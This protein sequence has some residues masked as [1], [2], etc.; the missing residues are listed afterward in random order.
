MMVLIP[1]SILTVVII[2]PLLAPLMMGERKEQVQGWGLLVAMTLFVMGVYLWRGEPDIPSQPALFDT[3]GPLAEKR[4]NFKKEQE[5][6]LALAEKP[7]DTE[8]MLA[9]GGVL[10]K[11]GNLD[12]AIAVLS[13]AHEREPGNAAVRLKLGTAYYAAALSEALLDGDRNRALEN[14]DKAVKTA[15]EDAPYRDRLLKDRDDFQREPAS[16]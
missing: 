3:Q 5:L 14:F 2:V 10:M 9:L 1:A 15:P 8:R 13:K 11:N 12:D 6:A 7:E 4:A 16:P